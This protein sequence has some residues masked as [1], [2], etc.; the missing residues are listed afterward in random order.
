MHL[1]NY[2]CDR[3]SLEV[4]IIFREDFPVYGALLLWLA[5]A[6]SPLLGT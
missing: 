4:I 3:T 5:F 6:K 1:A 2:W